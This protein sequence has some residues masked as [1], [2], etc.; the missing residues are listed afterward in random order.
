MSLLAKTS[1]IVFLSNFSLTATDYQP[2]PSLSLSLSISLCHAPTTTVDCLNKLLSI[3]ERA[4][5]SQCVW[6]PLGLYN[7]K[8]EQVN[9][10]DLVDCGCDSVV[11]AGLHHR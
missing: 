2:P 11:L 1:R 4:L 10:M 9:P 5:Q 8:G 3:C 6:K 7:E